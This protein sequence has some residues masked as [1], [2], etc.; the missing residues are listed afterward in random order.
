MSAPKEPTARPVLPACERKALSVDD[1]IPYSGV[2]R[3]TLYKFLAEGRLRSLKVGRKR[4]ILREDLDDLL[5]A[6]VAQ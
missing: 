2:G 6:E 5:M 1:A 4:L 3:T